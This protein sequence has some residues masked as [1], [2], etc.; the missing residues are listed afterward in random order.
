MDEIQELKKELQQLRIELEV[1]KQKNTKLQKELE[2]V[3]RKSGAK[4]IHQN[5]HD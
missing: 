5:P 1:E 2:M 4:S 3:R